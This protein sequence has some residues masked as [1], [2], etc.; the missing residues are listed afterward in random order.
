MRIIFG[1]S[2]GLLS[3]F[4][5]A[6]NA[7][8]SKIKDDVKVINDHLANKVDIEFSSDKEIY[9][10]LVLITDSLGQTYFLDNRYRFKGNYKHSVDFKDYHKGVYSV[11]I[12]G[13][14]DKIDKK[15]NVK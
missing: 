13:D 4:L 11:K 9:N 6:Q 8:S 3:S 12:I 2:F 1:F 7:G 14:D 5:S 15:I 10:L